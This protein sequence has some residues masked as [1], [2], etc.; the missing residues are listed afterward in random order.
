MKDYELKYLKKKLI[1]EKEKLELQLARNKENKFGIDDSVGNSM[2]ELSMY[3]NHPADV[4]TETFEQQKY[5][6]LRNHQLEY[7]GDIRDA[8]GRMDRGNYGL[9][10]YCENK[11]GFERLDAYPTAKL[12]ISCQKNE[13]SEEV[14]PK[15]PVEEDVLRYPFG[16]TFTD[17][18]DAAGYDGEDAWQ[19]VEK[20]G[21]SSGPQDISVNRLVNYKNLFQDSDESL[22]VV[23][24]VEQIDNQEYMEQLPED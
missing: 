8:L 17:G 15:R 10:V 14:E 13:K 9:C 20:Y 3:D 23:E 2:E 19:D 5:I 21:T 16:R 12:C 7:L 1:K 24:K 11:I 6:S 4:G 22:G 18:R